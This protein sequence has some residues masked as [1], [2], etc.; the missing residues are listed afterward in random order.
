MMASIKLAA[1]TVFESLPFGGL[2]PLLN[3]DRALSDFEADDDDAE[4]EE[5]GDG[6]A[7]GA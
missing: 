7:E 3:V 1:V 4:D 6:E 2:A 5:E